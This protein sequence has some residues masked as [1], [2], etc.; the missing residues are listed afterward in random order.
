MKTRLRQNFSSSFSMEEEQ[1]MS[2]VKPTNNLRLQN[3]Q[4]VLS[5]QSSNHQRAVRKT[6]TLHS[7]EDTATTSLEL[8]EDLLLLQHTSSNDTKVLVA[9]HNQI[10]EVKLSKERKGWIQFP[11]I[12]VNETEQLMLQVSQNGTV[13][14]HNIRT[15][16]A[17][18]VGLPP[19]SKLKG[20]KGPIIQL[21][22][23]PV[24]ELMINSIGDD[25]QRRCAG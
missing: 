25:G 13:P 11:Y 14:C 4:L 17:Q 1:H 18:I 21:D 16:S 10:E 19:P 6:D 24:Y 23:G 2:I 12:T 20:N 8:R 5:Q 22:A 15:H 9:G 3:D 7:L